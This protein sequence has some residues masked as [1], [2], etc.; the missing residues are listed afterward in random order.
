MKN[1]MFLFLAVLITGCSEIPKP[2]HLISKDKM[3][4]LFIDAALYD[5][6]FLSGRNVKMEG[7]TQFILKKHEVTAQQYTESYRY[8]L[9]KQEIADIVELAKKKL[10]K[11]HPDLQN[12]IDKKEAPAKSKVKQEE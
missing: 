9:S 6:T 4:A 12:Y 5:N 11:E 2:D 7:V 3:A 1:W 8:Y 10:I